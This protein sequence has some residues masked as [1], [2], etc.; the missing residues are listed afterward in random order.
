MELKHA[1]SLYY[2]LIISNLC[3][4]SPRIIEISSWITSSVSRIFSE[5]KNGCTYRGESFTHE[6]NLFTYSTPHS[7]VD[8]LF[9]Q[10][11]LLSIFFSLLV[12]GY[13]RW[14][15][16]SAVSTILEYRNFMF[17]EKPSTIQISP[18][19]VHFQ[20]L[21]SSLT[22]LFAC[23]IPIYGSLTSYQ[24][25]LFEHVESVASNISQYSS[26]RLYE[27]LL[28]DHLF[29]NPNEVIRYYS[30]FANISQVA[31]HRIPPPPPNIPIYST[32]RYFGDPFPTSLNLNTL[33]ALETSSGFDYSSIPTSYMQFCCTILSLIR[34]IFLKS[35]NTVWCSLM[36]TEI[37]CSHIYALCYIFNGIVTSSREHPVISPNCILNLSKQILSTFHC[38]LFSDSFDYSLQ[39]YFLDHIGLK[40][41]KWPLYLSEPQLFILS[42]LVLYHMKTSVISSDHFSIRF[43]S[44]FISSLEQGLS[45]SNNDFGQLHDV[46]FPHIQIFLFCFSSIPRSY[47]TSCFIRITHLL[48]RFSNQSFITFTS[49]L[50]WLRVVLLFEYFLFHFTTP[51]QTLVHYIHSCFGQNA[52]F[53]L[54]QTVPTS[55]FNDGLRDF[56]FNTEFRQLFKDS[57]PILYD[58]LNRSNLN[59]DPTSLSV[60]C[61]LYSENLRNYTVLYSNLFLHSIS[62]GRMSLSLKSKRTYLLP[63]FYV[64]RYKSLKNILLHLPCFN[65]VFPPNSTPIDIYM[66]LSMNALCKSPHLDEHLSF[67]LPN[68]F[69]QSSFLRPIDVIHLAE[70]FFSTVSIFNTSYFIP[71]FVSTSI[72][73]LLYETMS[74]LEQSLD[75][76]QENETKNHRRNRS[77][78]KFLL[79]DV[80]ARFVPLLFRFLNIL[81]NECSL[82]LSEDSHHGS[83]VIE[84]LMYNCA[85]SSC[86]DDLTHFSSTSNPELFDSSLT[87][88]TKVALRSYYN[89]SKIGFDQLSLFGDCFFLNNYS[90]L[91]ILE[92][93]MISLT[94]YPCNLYAPIFKHCISTIS[95][96][97]QHILG[98]ISDK[99]ILSSYIPEIAVLIH[100]AP[101]T[102]L[103]A[104]GT[105]DRFIPSRFHS[106]IRDA[107]TSLFLK[108][109][110]FLISLPQLRNF[111]NATTVLNTYYTIL[112][113]SMKDFSIYRLVCN[114]LKN[115]SSFNIFSP[116][117]LPIYPEFRNS[118]SLSIHTLADIFVCQKGN[119]V[120]E[121]S[122]FVSQLNDSAFLNQQNIFSYFDYAMLGFPGEEEKKIEE[123]CDKLLVFANAI[124]TGCT[125]LPASTCQFILKSIIP[126]GDKLLDFIGQ[127]STCCLGKYSITLLLLSLLVI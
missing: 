7:R 119:F 32:S 116:L 80:S 76:S 3:S 92:L 66:T 57:P 14:Y 67:L 12:N 44:S 60:I 1:S 97:L 121:S 24:Q 30:Q 89:V 115:G 19:Y 56:F 18:S 25:L 86:S 54:N 79:S 124:S 125:I 88:S 58:I 49:N 27:T 64:F 33:E 43:L 48:Q 94:V 83:D 126:L 108:N 81:S 106:T 11:P 117:F 104:Q 61:H 118:L 46:N 120:L 47:Q 78:I 122:I 39:V 93:Y 40:F 84:N 69:H 91:D 98:W 111:S 2:F 4:L 82:Y 36:N 71:L 112:L 59:I 107:S 103:F 55:P 105:I 75:I 62:M 65:L 90:L 22:F 102:S 26:N 17:I 114:I 9:D 77:L 15:A 29:V 95:S 6:A 101:Q 42:W 16:S 10:N 96:F 23:N 110:F 72:I 100:K 13:S 99:D 50:I 68:Q 70:K 21:R 35:K 38:I 109:S 74:T 41:D 87:D 51:P 85:V 34:E 28:L 37:E 8:Y 63:H 123:R 45:D 53:S 52:T 31:T 113:Q 127:L 20:D 5:V 73:Y